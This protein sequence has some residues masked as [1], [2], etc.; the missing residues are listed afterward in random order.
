MKKRLNQGFT[1]LEL[2]VVICVLGIILAFG[3]GGILREQRVQ[4]LRQVQTQLATD[5]E[6]A[7]SLARRYSYDYRG[8][9]TIST[10]V[11]VFEPINFAGT[12]VTGVPTVSGKL[13]APIKIMST[14]PSATTS[15]VFGYTGPFGRLS[16]APSV[17]IQIGF[18]TGQLKTAV[19]M[20][21]VTGQ[22]IRRGI[23]E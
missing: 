22:V 15:L 1:L 2:L 23:S 3:I 5:I 12:V 17:S 9:M 21:G 4:Q 16:G 8:T 10:G 6:R 20:I 7:R 11:Y 14:T 13:T 19:D 18:G